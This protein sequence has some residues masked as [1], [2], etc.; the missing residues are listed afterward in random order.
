M[1]HEE[2]IQELRSCSGKQFDPNYVTT[3]IQVINNS[4][5]PVVKPP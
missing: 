3:F 1:T 2:A 4:T 5:F